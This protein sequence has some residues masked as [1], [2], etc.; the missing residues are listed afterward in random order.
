MDVRPDGGNAAD[1]ECLIGDRLRAVV[2][3]KNES[4]R[5]RQETDETKNKANH[6]VTVRRDGQYV[7]LA[8]TYPHRPIGSIIH[9]SGNLSLWTGRCRRRHDDAGG[10]P[11]GR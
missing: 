5:E 8:T 3:E 11:G 4:Q 6:G 7:A 10:T 9:V 2:N 1:I